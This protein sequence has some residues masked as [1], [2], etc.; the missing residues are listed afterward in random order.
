[1][2]ELLQSELPVQARFL[3][4][5]TASM[6]D[7]VSAGG[8]AAGVG[9][10]PTEG[11]T[12]RIMDRATMIIRIMELAQTRI[13]SVH[14]LDTAG[15]VTTSII[16]M[17]TAI[18]NRITTKKSQRNRKAD[19]MALRFYCVSDYLNHFAEKIVAN[20]YYPFISLKIYTMF[21]ANVICTIFYPV[22]IRPIA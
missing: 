21:W 7:S 10:G 12:A 14:G 2:Q 18:I 8:P 17:M 9:V 22:D 15:N 6:A 3:W 19:P 13:K 5:N 11:A 1:M 20:C 16:A 4:R